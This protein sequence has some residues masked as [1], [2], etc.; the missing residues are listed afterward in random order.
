MK[1][2][3]SWVVALVVGFALGIVSAGALGVGASRRSPAP[4]AAAPAARPARPVEDPRAVY[5]VPVDGSPSKGPADALVT[6]VESSDFQCPFCKR[7]APT[8]KQLEEAYPGKVRFVFKHNPLSI[9]PLAMNAA[10]A[11][12]AA[13]AQGGD[14]RFWAMHD[15]LFDASPALEEAGLYAAAQKIGLDLAQFKAALAAGAGRDRVERDQRLVTSLGATGTP[16]FFINGRKISGAYPLDAFKKIVDEELAKAEAMEKAGTPAAQVYDRIMQGAATAQVV[17]QP[18]AAAPGPDAQ[19]PQAAP[20]LPPAVYRKVT[21]RPDDPVRG[22]ADAPVT[23]V[24]FSDFQCPFCGRVEPTLSQL[25]K[26]YAGKVRMVWKHQPLPMHPNAIPAA[27]A[28]EAAREQGKFWEMHDKL[29]AAQQDLNPATYERYAKELGLDLAK[30][31]AAVAAERGKDRIAAD[32]A[33]AGSAGVNG[34]PTMFLNCRQ[35]VGAVPYETIKTALEEELAKTTPLLKGGKAGPGFYAQACDANLALAAAAPAEAAPA[36]PAPTLDAG[37]L[38]LRPDDPVRGNP[39]APVTVVLFSDFQ[40]PFCSRIEPTLTQVEKTYGDKVKVVWKHQPLPM[41]PNAIPAAIA[42][43][44]AREQGKFWEMHDKLFAAQQDLSPATYERYASELGL[45][46]AR[47]KAAVAASHGQ[48]RIA[49][50][51]ALAGKVGVSGTPTLFVNG[52]RVVGAV[53]FEQIKTVID[54]QLARK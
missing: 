21:L 34:T 13:R 53:P 45:D 24:V 16:A 41:H 12:E 11:A 48:D 15:A 18:T 26:A 17:T 2:H 4:S 1:Q 20:G 5:R 44:A 47:F 54:R 49:A 52:E 43:E 3:V 33:L 14:A 8:L 9:H 50:D 35:V 28:A 31:K 37:A 25:Q 19:R 32:Q 30:F 46:L 10:L 42:A 29:F 22:E 38:A 36:A 7:V 6:I 23:M 27:I 51:Q 40:C 39:R